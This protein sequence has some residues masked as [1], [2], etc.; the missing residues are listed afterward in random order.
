MPNPALHVLPG[1]SLRTMATTLRTTIPSKIAS[2]AHW[3]NTVHRVPPF[4]IVVPQVAEHLKT[5][6]PTKLVV[7][8]ARVDVTKHKQVKTS[9]TFA[10]AENTNLKTALH[11][12]SHATLD[13]INRKRGNRAAPNAPKIITPTNPNKRHAKRAATTKPLFKAL[14]F[15]SNVMRADSCPPRKHARGAN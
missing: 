10:E 2:S 7:Y 12:V 8:R 11:F 1:S 6:L 4:A 15:V 14:H 13:C 9:A 5:K 3:V